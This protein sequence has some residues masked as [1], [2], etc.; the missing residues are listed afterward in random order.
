MRISQKRLV[1]AFTIFS[2]F[3]VFFCWILSEMLFKED[4]K[5]TASFSG[6]IYNHNY[7]S[8]EDGIWPSFKRHFIMSNVVAERNNNNS[9]FSGVACASEL[10]LT[11]CGNPGPEAVIQSHLNIKRSTD[12]NVERK[13]LLNLSFRH[14]DVEG[15][16]GIISRRVR[17]YANSLIKQYIKVRP[18]IQQM[19][20]VFFSK[21]MKGYHVLAVHIRGT[22]HGDEMEDGK[23]P[24]L[25]T[26]IKNAEYHFE[27][28]PSP[29]KIFIASDN[30][31]S[32]RKFI[33]EF[34]DKV[35]FTKA[36]RSYNY[37]GM[38]SVH[39]SNIDHYKLGTEVLVD[40]LLMAKCRHFLHAESSVASLV[41][42]FNPDIYTHFLDHIPKEKYKE[43]DKKVPRKSNSNINLHES[44]NTYS[45]M[46]ESYECFKENK[47]YSVCENMAEGKFI[48]FVD[49]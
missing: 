38:D 3:I 16:E 33:S 40:I 11:T 8:R 29:K 10:Y 34:G 7:T 12:K 24:Q 22:D 35:I 49:W 46:L 23:L 9:N 43:A 31:E 37:E 28:L 44:D 47:A 4:V 27:S 6:G 19:V 18:N 42:Y 26:W 15:F 1:L 36:H 41:A 20:D 13:S 17:Q 32:I 5:K 45:E 25:M 14:R 2:L 39:L 21:Y 48:D 30:S